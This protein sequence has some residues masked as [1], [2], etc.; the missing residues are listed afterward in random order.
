LKTLKEINEIMNTIPL[1]WRKRWCESQYCACVGCVQI[2]NRI[3]MYEKATGKKFVGDPEY[4][5][6]TE[7]SQAIYDK[8][9]ISK[10]EWQLWMNRIEF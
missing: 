9:K 3:I 5:S 6:E 8:Y 7:I 1:E 4:I 10:E 2:G